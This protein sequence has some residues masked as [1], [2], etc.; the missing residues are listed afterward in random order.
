MDYNLLAFSMLLL[1]TTYIHYK[2]NKSYITISFC[3][4][5]E[6]DTWVN[7]IIYKPNDSEELFVRTC[8]EFENKFTQK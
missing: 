8:Q 6:N 4:I 7:A 3:K 1:N 5:Q 2:N